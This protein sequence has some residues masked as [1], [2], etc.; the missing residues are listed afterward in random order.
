MGTSVII[1]LVQHAEKIK[2]GECES[3]KPGMPCRITEAWNVGDCAAQGDLLIVVLDKVPDSFS[4][5]KNPKDVDRQLVPGNTIGAKHCL[6]S[7]NGVGIYR[8]ADWGPES[9]DGPCLRVL[10]NRTITH[11]VHGDVLIPAGTIVGIY[12]QREWDRELAKER[13]SAD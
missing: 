2:S 13:R 11:P 12:Y 7:L 3:V 10:S 5:V 1:S 9:T 6:D 8:R 4:M